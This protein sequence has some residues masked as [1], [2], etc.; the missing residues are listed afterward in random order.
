V[1]LNSVLKS[2]VFQ[3]SPG[4]QFGVVQQGAK[5]V[6]LG[7]V[8]MALMVGKPALVPP[9][10]LK[11]SLGV[12]PG[13]VAPFLFAMR[14][15]PAVVDQSV[16]GVEQVVASAGSPTQSLRFAPAAFNAVGHVIADVTEEGGKR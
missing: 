2:L 10:I 16:L 7:K 6:D 8:K 13:T 14:G 4:G 3:A 5:R 1:P 15:I 12:E 11:R 9:G